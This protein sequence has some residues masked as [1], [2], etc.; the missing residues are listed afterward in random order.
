MHG[1]SFSV[2]AHLHFISSHIY[3]VSVIIRVI[4]SLGGEVRRLVLI[5][6]Q[7]PAT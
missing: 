2:F 6:L 4:F 3:I 5:K 1:F 7:G